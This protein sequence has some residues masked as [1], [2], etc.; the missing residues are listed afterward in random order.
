MARSADA[1]AEV[2][3]LIRSERQLAAVRSV[4]LVRSGEDSD[5]HMDPDALRT[6][7]EAG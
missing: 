3:P 6:V 7:G 2:R 4:L 1:R 5:M